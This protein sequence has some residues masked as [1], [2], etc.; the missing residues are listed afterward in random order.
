MTRARGD[1]VYAM[2]KLPS[3]RPFSL[4]VL[5]ISPCF[6]FEHI[7]GCCVRGK[8]PICFENAGIRKGDGRSIRA[9]AI[10]NV[11]SRFP[12]ASFA[13]IFVI[14]V[15]FLSFLLIPL[16]L[17]L[18]RFPWSRFPFRCSAIAC[19]ERGRASGNSLALLH[20]SS[21]PSLVHRSPFTC[22]VYFLG[23]G[24]EC[25]RRREMLTMGW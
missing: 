22:C 16:P 12:V 2:S 15:I 1:R 8:G 18:P 13:T 23:R 21:L 20:P 14:F 9:Y 6:L 7:R 5:S 3:R 25:K 17:F 19:R 24:G 4:P 11:V 10:S